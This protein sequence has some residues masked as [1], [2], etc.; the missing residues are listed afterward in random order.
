M[1]PVAIL[2]QIG[3][4]HHDLSGIPERY[5]PQSVRPLLVHLNETKRRKLGNS[6]KRERGL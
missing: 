6:M 3:S 2:Q 4:D 5:R 1:Q